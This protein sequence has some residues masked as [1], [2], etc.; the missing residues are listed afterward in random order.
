[1]R[2]DG[3][4][5]AN[6]CLSTWYYHRSFV[7]ILHN[8]N[9]SICVYHHRFI[10]PSPSLDIFPLPDR[11]YTRDNPDIWTFYPEILSWHNRVREWDS[12]PTSRVSRSRDLGAKCSRVSSFSCSRFFHFFSSVIYVLLCIFRGFMYVL[13][14]FI[15]RL[16]VFSRDSSFDLPRSSSF[17]FWGTVLNTSDFSSSFYLFPHTL[18]LL[19]LSPSLLQEKRRYKSWSTPTIR[20]Y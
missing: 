1:M 13:I 5:L 3:K 16:F 18:P 11:P 2:H 10:S 20:W 7:Y 17:R 6:T 12:G 8:S 14:S 9:L 15:L 4:N 19:P